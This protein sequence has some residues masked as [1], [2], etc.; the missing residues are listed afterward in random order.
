MQTSATK[1]DKNSKHV[2]TVGVLTLILGFAAAYFIPG[3]GSTPSLNLMTA[4]SIVIGAM[5][6]AVATAHSKF[7]N[8]IVNAI[9]SAAV[10]TLV[11]S[12]LYGAFEQQ[13][14][15]VVGIVFIGSFLAT[16]VSKHF[17]K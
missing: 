7:K 9:V 12:L 8:P 5:L 1:L 16:F 3:V 6:G 17:N 11:T 14:S 2:L 10:A 13:F 4:I 15:A